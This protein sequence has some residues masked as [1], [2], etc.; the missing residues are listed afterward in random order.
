[1]FAEQLVA[2]VEE[3]GPEALEAVPA[4]IEA[5]LASRL[6]RLDPAD[7]A[8]LGRAATVGRE[9]NKQAVGALGPIE[10]LSQ[11]EQA[12]LVHGTGDSF[13]F[14]HV[15]IRDV[16]YASIPKTERAALHEQYANWLAKQGRQVEL[17]EILGYHL[18]QAYRY[19]AELGHTVSELAEQA[20]DRLATVGRR[21]FWRGDYRAAVGLL[22]RALALSRP[23]RLDLHLELDLATALAD[24][25][26]AAEV[27]ETAAE[28]AREA[29]DPVGEA[30]A[31]VVAAER[32]RL[33]SRD[34]GVDELDALAH[35]ALPMLKQAGDH[36]G[37]VH[38]WYA[39]G[40]VAQVRGQ[41]EEWAQALEQV[42]SHS[43][44]TGH[45]RGL[46]AG[47]AAALVAGPRPADDALRTLEGQP[48]APRPM[49]QLHRAWLLAMLG[50]FD[51][52]WAIARPANEQMHEFTGGAYGGWTQLASISTLAGDHETAVSY[53]RECC[54]L[55]EASG[56]RAYLS[57]QAPM[58][59]RS[60]CYLGRHG[61]AE[62]LAQIGREL[63]DESNLLT[64]I[65]WRQ[66]LALVHA[67]ENQHEQAESLAREAVTIAKRTDSLN[68]HA[69]ALCDL[70]EVLATAGRQEAA[71]AE[72]ENALA[73]Y[74]QKR[75]LAMAER[76]RERLTAL[77]S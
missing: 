30:T 18:E 40:T 12:G 46:R 4:S 3:E 22:E 49:A 50:R 73:L 74:E 29:D 64:Q 33:L 14:H 66:T 37:L 9:F 42:L 31:R 2:Y 62:P 76:A 47:L 35:A 23:I 54:E 70:A 68:T 8:L 75:N 25:R 67:N 7:R 38:V 32:R 65:L 57:T 17:D 15:L 1:L 11:L 36:T 39:I 44:H 61:E 24:P 59:G 20:S 55:S 58:L 51:E 77:R 53:L 60:L 19:H 16:A 69:D 72:L 56:R 48:E 27:A 52:A 6:D 26:Q 41:N 13:R 43:R 5:L 63:S 10:A 21:A 71:A 45:A 28:R 34:H